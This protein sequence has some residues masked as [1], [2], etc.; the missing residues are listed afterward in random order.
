MQDYFVFQ[1]CRFV[2]VDAMKGQ[3]GE[4]FEVAR[5]FENVTEYQNGLCFIRLK[6]DGWIAWG[7]RKTFG[8]TFFTKRRDGQFERI[9]PDYVVFKCKKQD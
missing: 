5:K 2:D 7:V 8:P 6:Y 1:K 4:L 9:D 3:D